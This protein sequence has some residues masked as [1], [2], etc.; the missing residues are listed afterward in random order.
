MTTATTILALVPI[1]TSTGRGGDIMRPMAVPIFGGM[2]IEVITM[3][4]VPVVFCLIQEL[5]ASE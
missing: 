3:L 5:K 1:I 4:I 2:F